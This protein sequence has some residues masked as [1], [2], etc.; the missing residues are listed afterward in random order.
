MAKGNK[1][2]SKKG[3][4]DTTVESNVDNNVDLQDIQLDAEEIEAPI[5]E[6]V[7]TPAPIV[8]EVIKETVIREVQAEQPKVA[9]PST[10][11]L[12]DEIVTIKYI[13]KEN[14]DI[15]DPKHVGYGGLFVGSSIAIPAPTL[16]NARMKNILTN[17]EKAGL[18]YLLGIDLSIYGPFWK[19]EFKRGGIFPILLS[20]E[21]TQL[22]LSDPMQY[23]TWKTLLASPIVA[24]SIDEIRNRATYRFVL[25]SEGEELR[26]SKDKI[27]N[28]VLAFEKYVE[29]KNNK[30]V[31]RYILRNLG[32]YTSRGQKL[33]FLQVECA[34]EIEKDPNMFV[35]ITNDKLI[36]QKVLLEEGVEFGV[37]TERDKKYYTL[38]N[39]PISEGDTPTLNTAA[40]HLASPLG[41]E[42][43][44]ALEAKIKNARE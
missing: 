20:K 34:K 15:K 42:M 36:L 38:D 40:T 37:V 5:V 9:L 23:I 12:R 24:N 31:L 10:A 13:N 2:E 27:G 33:D 22:D 44:L 30:G 4:E 43:R 16:D 17:E 18:E 3:S 32:K 7:E 35:A 28:K 25:V 14:A 39:Q 11:F 1:D 6:K 29:F 8:Q 19:S 26:K 41:Q 21:D